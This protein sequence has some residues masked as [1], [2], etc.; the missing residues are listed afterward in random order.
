MKLLTKASTFFDSIMGLL[1][2]LAA[3]LLV[4]TMLSVSYDVVM[5]YFLNRP[6]LWV[7]EIAE[8]SLLYI[9]FL[10]VAWLL[11]KEGHV[12]MDL[13]ISRLNPETQAL[14]NVITS[15]ICAVIC[16][17]LVWYGVQVTWDSFQ[18]GYRSGTELDI[19]RWPM[20]AIIPVGSFLLF[21][22]FL[23]RTFRYLGSWR[24]S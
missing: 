12:K 21:I 19:F 20:D 13:V 17:L 10:G 23:R 24:A 7:Q 3:V 8:Y 11:K 14:L 22:Q 9:T 15:V 5:R 2:F 1:A 6:T 16:A 4:F 18:V